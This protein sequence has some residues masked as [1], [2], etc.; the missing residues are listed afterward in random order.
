MEDVAGLEFSDVAGAERIGPFIVSL[1][2]GVIA[3]VLIVWSL[4]PQ[5][6]DVL[7]G[8]NIRAKKDLWEIIIKP[9]Q[10]AALYTGICVLPNKIATPF[11][12]SGRFIRPTV[13]LSCQAAF[14][15]GRLFSR[16]PFFQAAFFDVRRTEP[17]G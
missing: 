7:Q 5:I 14:F 12:P 11:H 9:R 17:I 16:P 4:A 3:T 1:V 10:F 15:P 6:S 8:A 2:I 13:I